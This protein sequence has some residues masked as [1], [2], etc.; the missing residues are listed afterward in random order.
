MF[1]PRAASAP[2]QHRRPR[3]GRRR[4]ARVLVA[5]RHRPRRRPVDTAAA[6]GP[7]CPSSASTRGDG[8][9]VRTCAGTAS[10]AAR[11]RGL[12]HPSSTTGGRRHPA[13]RHAPTTPPPGWPWS[14]SSRH[15]SAAAARGAHTLTNTRPCAY[16]VDGLEVVAALAATS[17]DA[18]LHRP[19]RGRAHARSGTPSPTGSWLREGATGRPASTA[20]PWS[21]PG[22][23][24]FG[25]D[26][27]EVL[28]SARRGSGNSVI[29]SSAQRR[30]GTTIGGGELLLPGEVAAERGVVHLPLGVFA[31]SSDEGLDGRVRP[32]HLQRHCPAHPAQQPVCSTSGRRSTSTTTSTG[33]SSSPTGAR[34]WASSGS[35]STTAGSTVVATTPP[36]WVTG[37]STSTVWPEGSARSSSTSVAGHAVRA[38]VRAGDGQ[39]GLRPL[40]RPPRLD[41]VHREHGS[42]CTATSWCSTSTRP[43]VWTTSSTGGRGARRVPHRL[44]EVGPQPRPARG[45]LARAAGPR[46]RAQTVAF[47][48][49]LDDLRAAIPTS[50]GSRAP[51]AA[52]GSTS[53]CSSGCSGWT[54]DMTDALARQRSSGGPSSWSRP[55][56]SAR[57]SRRPRRTPPAG[58]CRWTSG[59]RRRSS[60]R[61]ASSGT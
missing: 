14:T 28:A 41:P 55:S 8:S 27:G 44:R 60:V 42:R 4:P 56:T 5:G 33:C 37:G 2:A 1:F 7:G 51:R 52:A 16:L 53:A 48:R 23:P 25:I 36:D 18:R 57:T 39:P 35:C 34:G 15:S 6:N 40:P 29:G 46:P 3:R 32:A 26:H 54:S 45:R 31:A 9:P 49:L 47:Y 61:S 13:R 58:L 30:T 50:P 17:R 22:P 43:E 19:P 20:R 12:V 10:A 11:R 24:G 59:P 21:S 38:L